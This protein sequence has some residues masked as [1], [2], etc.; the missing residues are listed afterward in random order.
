MNEDRQRQ[1]AIEPRCSGLVGHRARG[2]RHSDDDRVH[3]L[4]MAGIRG[5]RDVI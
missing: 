3:R 1:R 2:P 5:Q 4:Q